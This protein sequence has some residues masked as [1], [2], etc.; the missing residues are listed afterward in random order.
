MI[1]LFCNGKR[2]T[3][4]VLFFSRTGSAHSYSPKKIFFNKLLQAFKQLQDLICT[5]KNHKKG[6]NYSRSFAV[7]LL[8]IFHT[9]ESVRT[10][11]NKTHKP[12]LLVLSVKPKEHV[13]HSPIHF[14]QPKL[15]NVIFLQ[16]LNSCSHYVL[17]KSARMNPKQEEKK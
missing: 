9:E 5:L 15:A 11:A 14:Q 6:Q 1:H 2:S 8:V 13:K 4:T 17:H 12:V 7:I 3:V 10:N 16:F